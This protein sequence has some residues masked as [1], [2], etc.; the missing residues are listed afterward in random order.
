[1]TNGVYNAGNQLT[2]FGSSNFTYDANGNMTGDGVN[3]YT[4]DAR[5]HL[6]SITGTVSANFQ[7]DPFGRR[8]TKMLGGTT[9]YLYD[10]VN[11]VE[12][13]SGGTPSANLL[14][15][16]AAD[17]YFQRADSSGPANFLTE[18]LGSTIAVTGAS[19]NTL[20][21]YTYEPFGN[22]TIAGSSANP[23]QYAGREND[24]T[25]LY[26][27]RARFYSPTTGRFISEDPIGLEGGV[28]FYSYVGNEPTGFSDP[29]GLC[30]KQQCIENFLKN[31]Y[32]NFVGGTVVPD[33]SLISIGSNFWGYVKS[34]ALTL[35]V[36]G[37]L[38][39]VPTALSWVATTT[40][41]NLAAYPGMATA[42]AD[43][44]ESG[45]FWGT[46][47]ATAEWVIVPAAVGATAFSTTADLYARWTCRNVQ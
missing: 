47:A 39:T 4:W 42:S 23:Y 24:G 35:A 36:K 20:V 29:F 32:G 22:T 30:P 16:L 26:F 19:G 5:N 21:Q 15:G 27:Y 2:Q 9:Q 45:A 8:V 11:P 44:L 46:T 13:L 40:G 31:N 33:F 14:T 6:A 28:N 1:L 18:A 38:I 41:N 37:A 25:G 3:T 17:E 34:S 12:E 7:Y 10:G 43:A